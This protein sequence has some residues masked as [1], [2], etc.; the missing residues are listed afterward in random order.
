MPAAPPSALIVGAGLAGLAAARH[1]CDA[2]WRVQVVDEGEVPGGRLAT[3]RLDGGRHVDVG[4]QF[5]SARDPAF[6][7]AVAQWEERGWVRRWC[8]G[9]PL[10]TAAGLAD[11]RDGFARWIGAAG[12][13]GLARH[14]AEGLELRS[15]TV[16]AGLAP[17]PAGGWRATLSDGAKPEVDA[18]VL[19]LPAPRAAAFLGALHLPPP[20]ALAAIR[21]EPCL[22]LAVDLP[23]AP[24]ALLPAPGAVRVDDPA[25]PRTCLATAR[26]RGQ[27]AS[28]EL[29]LQHLR[30]GGD[31]GGGTREQLAAAAPTLARLGIVA[32]LAAARCEARLWRYSR[33]VAPCAEPFLRVATPAPLLLAGDGCGDCPRVEGAWLS[34]RAAALALAAG[35]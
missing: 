8:D 13:D 27:L 19:T 33:C 14:L 22:A 15:A 4:G 25:S 16:L 6:A 32:D 7:A 17:A 34:G 9:I 21:Y 5:M 10:L 18:V 23:A 2:G 3:L 1:L 20:A 28:G 30:A 11:G 24:G 12:M 29:L 26:G 35:R 31:G